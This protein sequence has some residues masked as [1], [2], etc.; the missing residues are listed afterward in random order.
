ML[1]NATTEHADVADNKIAPADEVAKDSI[2]RLSECHCGLVQSRAHYSTS[3][4]SSSSTMQ[5]AFVAQQ[6]T[7]AFKPALKAVSHCRNC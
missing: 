6:A 2:C 1:F 5:T 4:R 7:A 3:Y